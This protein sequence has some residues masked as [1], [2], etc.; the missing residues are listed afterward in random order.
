M[1]KLLHKIYQ[2]VPMLVLLSIVFFG[3]GQSSPVF[4]ESESV[5]ED[6]IEE[7]PYEENS[8]LALNYHRVR[9]KN[10]PTMLIDFMS[11]TKE[12][13]I[14]SVYD[15]EFE[16]QM[17]WL[18]SQGAN[19]L[20]LDQAIKCI[21]T[22][23]VPEKAVWI[24]FDDMDQTIYDNAQPILEKYD[25]PATG[26]VITGQVGNQNFNSISLMDLESLVELDESGLWSFGLHTDD[27]HY[28]DEHNNSALLAASDQTV[29]KDT[30]KSQDYLDKYLENCR[31][32]AIAYPYGQMNDQTQVSLAEQG[33]RY[34]FTLE[35]KAIH[36]PINDFYI[37]R[38][39]VSQ[40][41][42]ERLVKSWQGFQ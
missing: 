12:L 37:P 39:L 23:N 15:D 6:P 32:D 26:F 41:S 2:L 3:G 30:K 21:E 29:K 8:I 17:K 1:K 9:E 38:V 40:E 7:L 11:N 42:F 16:D 19:F 28:L 24:S 10:F 22:G 33:V 13:Q 5:Q 20:T 34:G 4:A 31:T 18:K 27:L 14:Y 36:N 35:E 25:I